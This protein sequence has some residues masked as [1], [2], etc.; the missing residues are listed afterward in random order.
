MINA[1]LTEMRAALDARTVSAVELAT[2]FLERIARVD[3]ALN[4]FITVAHD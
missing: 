2:L 3:P 1:S 4:A